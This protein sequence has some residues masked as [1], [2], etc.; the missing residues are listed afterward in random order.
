VDAIHGEADRTK[1]CGIDGVAS[2]DWGLEQSTYCPLASTF[3][4][5][6]SKSGV[7]GRVVG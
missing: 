2:R 4:V 5:P 7:F 6:C 1:P 3:G